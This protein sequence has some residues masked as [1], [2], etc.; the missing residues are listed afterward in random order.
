MRLTATGRNTLRILAIVVGCSTIGGAA[1]GIAMNGANGILDPRPAAI[2]AYN[3]FLISLLIAGF[4]LHSRRRAARSWLG[5]SPFLV[6][7]ILRS[8]IYLAVFAL[9]IQSS[10]PVAGVEIT[11]WG[12]REPNFLIAVGVSFAASIAFNA[13]VRIGRVLGRGVLVKFLTGYYYRPREEERIFLF[14]DLVGSTAT[15]E[16]I[17]HIAFHRLMNDFIR[18]ATEPILAAHG[19]IHDYVGDEIIVTWT[20]ERGLKQGN[21]VRCVNDVRRALEK[22][23]DAY[24]KAY[25]IAPKFR[26]ALHI[27]TVAAGEMGLVK[28]AIVYLGD[29]VNTT[30]RI[31]A[32]CRELDADILVSADVVDRLA[33][34]SGL[35]FADLGSV[36]LRGRTEPVKLYS[37]A[38]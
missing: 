36:E 33:G 14:I 22:R 3:G 23:G 7:V 2:G 1:F 20:P 21:C 34:V 10:L 38:A 24:R 8:V 32:A 17:G 31:E 37:P 15:A 13:I 30:A 6:N 12:W 27:G 19:E 25:G 35:E 11:G 5:R 28:Q 29:I 18:D 16:R 4:E 9:V 26:A